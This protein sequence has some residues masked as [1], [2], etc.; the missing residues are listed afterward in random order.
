MTD[1]NSSTLYPP[2]S[3]SKRYPLLTTRTGRCTTPATLHRDNQQSE[4]NI[5]P[6]EDCWRILKH[7]GHTTVIPQQWTDSSDTHRHITGYCWIESDTILIWNLHSCTTL[8]NRH[9][10]K[11]RSIQSDYYWTSDNCTIMYHC[12]PKRT[13]SCR[14]HVDTHNINLILLRRHHMNTWMLY[15]ARTLLTL[16]SITADCNHSQEIDEGNIQSSSSESCFHCKSLNLS[17][18]LCRK[19]T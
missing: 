13:T 8:R 10:S 15:H 16:I 5:R 1:L 6:D 17:R 18:Q 4:H 12:T 14:A 2:D 9:S 3:C 11:H 7:T 19:H